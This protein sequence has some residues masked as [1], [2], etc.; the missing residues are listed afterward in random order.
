MEEPVSEVRAREILSD[1]SLSPLVPYLYRAGEVQGTP[2][3]DAEACGL[4]RANIAYL[5]VWQGV[6][7]AE[8]TAE[9]IREEEIDDDREESS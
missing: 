4:Q 7:I 9:E 1:G 2:V 5:Q 6:V 3:R 8:L